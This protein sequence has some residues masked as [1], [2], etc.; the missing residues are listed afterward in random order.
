MTINKLNTQ[1]NNQKGFSLKLFLLVVLSVTTLVL[2][3][4]Y[5]FVIKDGVKIEIASESNADRTNISFLK[6]SSD[7]STFNLSLNGEEPQTVDRDCFLDFVKQDPSTSN[8]DFS[9]DWE[10]GLVISAVSE[11][12]QDKINER[13]SSVYSD[14][15][16]ECSNAEKTN[17]NGDDA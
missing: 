15:V 12:S 11:M 1:M 2:G 5:A 16:K 8:P 14:M 9:V 6:V 13:M 7:I 10:N 17:T 4:T 3:L